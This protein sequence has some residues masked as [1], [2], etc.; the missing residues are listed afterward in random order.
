MAILCVVYIWSLPCFTCYKTE[1]IQVAI[2]VLKLHG[3]ILS[4]FDTG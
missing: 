2:K 4:R 3:Y 1:A